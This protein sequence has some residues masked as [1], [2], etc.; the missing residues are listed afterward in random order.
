MLVKD[1]YKSV[2]PNQLNGTFNQ[3]KSSWGKKLYTLLRSIE[4]L[5]NSHNRHRNC[6]QSVADDILAFDKNDSNNVKDEYLLGENFDENHVEDSIEQIILLLESMQE[7]F[8]RRGLLGADEDR[9]KELQQRLYHQTGKR[10]AGADDSFPESQGGKKRRRTGNDKSIFSRTILMDN[11]DEKDGVN[12][13]S[14]ASDEYLLMAALS[15][16]LTNASSYFDDKKKANDNYS[17][18]DGDNDSGKIE[19][20]NVKLYSPVILQGTINVITSITLHIIHGSYSSHYVHSVEYEFLVGYSVKLLNGL[21]VIIQHFCDKIFIN[22][23]DDSNGINELQSRIIFDTLKSCCKC[24]SSIIVISGTHLSRSTKTLEQVQAAAETALFAL[25]GHLDCCIGSESITNSMN[26]H[27]SSLQN[28]A[29]SLLATLPLASNINGTCPSELWTQLVHSSSLSLQQTI[30][31]FFPSQKNK[32]TTVFEGILDLKKLK[33]HMISLSQSKR[34]LHFQNRVTGYTY[35]LM[36]LLTKHGYHSPSQLQD[37]PTSLPVQ[38]LLDLLSSMVTFVPIAEARFL[39]MSKHS[40][41]IPIHNGLLSPSAAVVGGDII[42]LFAFDLIQIVLSCLNSA[43]LQYGSRIVRMVLYSLESCMSLALRRIV[44]PSNIVNSGLNAMNDGKSNKR[45]LSSLHSSVALRS[46]AVQTFGCAMQILGVNAIIT[47]CASVSK[48]IILVVGSMLEQL[49]LD[50]LNDEHWSTNGERIEHITTCVDVLTLCINTFGH[51]MPITTRE[52]IESLAHTSLFD[53]KASL[54]N[55]AFINKKHIILTYANVR[56]AILKLG[57][58]CICTQWKDGGT[59]TLVPPLLDVA[60]NLKL[61]VTDVSV[62]SFAAEVVRVCDTILTPRAPPLSIIKRNSSSGGTNRQESN[63]K[64]ENSVENE[65]SKFYSS[66]TLLNEIRNHNNELKLARQ[67]VDKKPKDI[68]TESIGDEEPKILDKILQVNEDKTKMTNCE[69]ERIH[70]VDSNTDMDKTHT[71]SSTDCL[72][73]EPNINARKKLNEINQ[74]N[75]VN[76]LE[77]K[78]KNNENE[79]RKETDD[80]MSDDDFPCIVDCDPDDKEG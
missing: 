11:I 4:R 57:K 44:D 2:P 22:D 53:M 21:S 63:D 42:K 45:Q 9:A 8:L 59:S 52:T 12:N 80:D 55:N 56:I 76:N 27:T 74:N 51:Y 26:T 75:M 29:A 10:D 35:L 66:S 39:H 33:E 64:Y 49:S 58:S 70:H 14:V 18:S 24:A 7:S 16:I 54:D 25:N 77:L 38:S 50:S 68:K 23:G 41:D 5:K 32:N 17:N 1:N 65:K 28:S 19:M 62:L 40:R 48:G 47:Q 79:N 69:I 60:S 30:H 72:P 71:L 34:V 73:S 36:N 43:A 67:H 31:L 46:K 20:F 13:Q 3:K 37:I 61:R 78:Q 15:R 6:S